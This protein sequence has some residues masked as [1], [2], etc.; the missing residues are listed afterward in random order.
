MGGAAL[1][2]GVAFVGGRLYDFDGA[3]L[4]AMRLGFTPLEECE[5]DEA[6]QRMAEALPPARRSSRL[7]DGRI[8]RPR[9]QPA[10]PAVDA[11]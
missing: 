8:G 9:R 6:V 10:I 2:R 4:Q 3:P 5:L 11:R 7:E 1:G